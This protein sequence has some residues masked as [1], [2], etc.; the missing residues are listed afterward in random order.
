MIHGRDDSSSTWACAKHSIIRETAPKATSCFDH[1]GPCDQVSVTCRCPN[2]LSLS[3]TV[4]QS[5]DRIPA[6][7]CRIVF[8]DDHSTVGRQY[9]RGLL[10]HGQSILVIQMVQDSGNQNCLK[11]TV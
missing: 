10:Q 8:P 4:N 6:A 9:S 5:T 7:D 3:K 1:K 2:P 11:T